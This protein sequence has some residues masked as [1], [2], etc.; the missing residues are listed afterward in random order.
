MREGAGGRRRRAVASLVHVPLLASPVSRIPVREHGSL[1]CPQATRR[2]R[3]TAGSCSFY[4]GRL[5][6]VACGGLSAL[7]FF[8]KTHFD[9][10]YRCTRPAANPILWRRRGGHE[11]LPGRGLL[12]RGAIAVVVLQ[13]PRQNRTRHP[14]AWPLAAAPPPHTA[15]PALF[16]VPPPAGSPALKRQ[17]P[18]DDA[19]EQQQQQQQAWRDVQPPPAR[20]RRLDSTP[21]PAMQAQAQQQPSFDQDIEPM[22]SLELDDEEQPPSPRSDPAPGSQSSGL[23]CPCRCLLPSRHR[24]PTCRR[25]RGGR[26]RSQTPGPSCRTHRPSC[27]PASWSGCRTSGARLRCGR[28]A[29]ALRACR[30]PGHHAAPSPCAARPFGPAGTA[31]AAAP[32]APPAAHV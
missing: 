8:R 26:P 6:R 12:S 7:S 28:R 25:R 4:K 3:G 29:W 5:S 15:A 1:V 18:Q 14:M 9:L 11:P 30:L 24:W 16:N 10:P 31:Q 32:H 17:R 27:P 2:A 23:C 13:K 20:R 21:P 19:E 22:P